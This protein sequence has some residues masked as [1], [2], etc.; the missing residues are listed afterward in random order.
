MTTASE[1][2]RPAPAADGS[3]ADPARRP[4]RDAL[5]VAGT[6]AATFAVL[7]LA[8]AASPGAD[9]DVAGY[10]V[11]HLFTGLLLVAAGG[12][13]LAI[14]GGG[15]RAGTA[16][17]AVF[18]VGLA[19]ALDEWVY[20]IATDGSNASYL[21]PVSLWGGVA[22][23]GL[24]IVYALAVGAVA[25][26]C[27]RREGAGGETGAGAGEVPVDRSS[28]G[29]LG[30]GRTAAVH[31]STVVLLACAVAAGGCISV[32]VQEVGA[33][34]G[35][36]AEGRR[37]VDLTHAFDADTVYWPTAEGFR[38]EEDFRGPTEGGYWYEANR[39]CA[40]EHGGT[41]LDAP[42]HFARGRHA[43]DEVP[44]DRLVGRAVTVDVSAAA[45]ADP[46]HEVSV[47]ELRDWE[48]EHGRI[49]PGAIVLLH[50]GYGRYWPDRA[51]YMGTDRRGP[52]AVADLRF[53][54]L[55]PDAARWLVEERAVGAVGIDT[56]SIDT[57]S[58]TLFWSHRVLFEQNV[59]AFENLANL[60]RL[61]PRG[62]TVVALPM[63][64]RGGSG[65][66]LRAIALLDR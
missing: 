31:A 54:G 66:P 37:I 44:L 36:L 64:I 62:F 6:M 8:L 46:G 59:P 30:G 57:G 1:A 16:A 43:A 13:P 55:H 28:A 51:R 14:R 39:F 15:G 2:P 9:L 18:A 23:V 53:P 4:L 11:H 3:G 34:G 61:P 42:V 29:G 45:L 50:T 58:S 32:Q 20:L 22:V 25:A 38:L 5:V 33:P 19:M 56:P 40:A 21:L 10:N 65:G 26:R 47:R 24:A 41:H 12:L 60:D 17:R 7:R 27:R 49:P 35:S 48:E 63:K 52:E